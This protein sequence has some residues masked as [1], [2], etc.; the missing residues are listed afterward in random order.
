MGD[1]LMTTHRLHSVLSVF[2]A[3]VLVKCRTHGSRIPF[4]QVP[5]E[6]FGKIHRVNSPA[7]GAKSHFLTRECLANKPLATGPSDLSVAANPSHQKA[8]AIFEWCQALWETS[9]GSCG[10]TLP[11]PFVPAPRAGADDCNATT[12]S[13][14]DAAAPFASGR[15]AWRFPVSS[16]HETA[17][18]HRCLADRPD[19]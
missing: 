1:T 19:G 5:D 17:R 4:V 11:E 8:L 9:A 14:S 6:Q 3:T 2:A 13:L 18:G 16:L 10:S 7:D 12:M 15:L